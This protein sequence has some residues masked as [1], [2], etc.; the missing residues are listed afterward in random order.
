MTRCSRTALVL[1][2]LAL[3]LAA[4]ASAQARTVRVFAVQ[5]KLDLNWMESRQTYHDKMLALADS[6]LRTP[7]APAV[8]RG[9]AD[10]ASHLLGPSDPGRP[11]ATARDLVVWPEDLGLFAAL[12]GPRAAGARSSGSFV[13]AIVALIGAYGPQNSYYTQRFPEAANRALPVRL[14]E[15]SLTDTYARTAVETFAEMA[16]RYDVYLE[17]GVNMVQDW[18]VVCDDLQA[19]NRA[20]PPRLPG[21]VLCQEQNP[22][23]V[24]QLGDPSELIRD[25]A[26][27]ATTDKV[28]NMALVFDPDGRLISKQVKTYLTPI[29]LPGQ[30]DLV[31]GLVTGGLSAVNTPVGTLGFVTSKDAWMP[32]V[33]AKLDEQHVDVLVQ[34]EFFVNDLVRA[35]GMW[36]P[37]TLKAAGY[38][39]ALRMPSV[40]AMALP[41]LTGNIFDFSADAQSHFALK[42]GRAPVPAGGLVGQPAAP[43][44]VSSPWVVTD[45]ASAGEPFADRRRR[46]G[47]AGKALA[48][49]SGVACADP[50]VAGP[51]E[52]GHVEGVFSHDVQVGSAPRFKRFRGRVKRARL[53]RARPVTS[54]RAPQRNAAIAVAGRRVAAAWEERRGGHDR[55]YFALSRDGGRH[56]PRALRLGGKGDQQWPAV[57]VGARRVTVAW[58]Q[59]A[60]A[61]PPGVMFARSARGGKRFGAARAIDASGAGAQWRPALA[62]G[63]GDTVHAV[64]VDERERSADDDLPQ[65]HV[66][67]ARIVRGAPSGGARKLDEDA[68]VAPA[69]KLDH[70]WAP[71]VAVRGKRVLATWLD[72]QNYDWGVFSRGSADGGASFGEQTRVTDNVEDPNKQQEEL[73]DSPDAAFTGAGTP[74]IAWTDWRGR[75]SAALAPHEEYDTF[76]ASPGGPNRQVDPY[77]ARQVS[78]FAPSLCA[79]GRRDAVVAFQD[80]SRGRSE[81]R[82]V[83]MR[84]GV[85]RGKARL[86]SDA[87]ARG[88][89]AWR[90]RLGCSGARVVAVWEDERDGPPRLY[91]ATGLARRLR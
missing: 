35:D 90:P 34:P 66:L 16:D 39:D 24:R 13:A 52:N 61:D 89:N 4:A 3:A 77:G 73:A 80:S 59:R 54:S 58:S 64:W 67:Y 47:E 21:G 57:A 78:T 79:I 48:P 7:A 68:P 45:P 2:L 37:D 10:L 26:Y 41:E 8:Q 75:D 5:P 29:E 9:A 19:F 6:R 69:A 31:P 32:D 17:V 53:G 72:F 46:L 18:K 74:L 70:A 85:T 28:S 55:V 76:V 44:L 87:G 12:T 42:P 82:A 63:S 15:V 56:W 81:I 22:Q 20:E 71:R 38:N 23:K 11:V 51:C 25:Y 40:K 88:G 84:G 49:G 1:A 62:Q 33:Q 60:G 65:A 36:S 83:T 91:S 14:T 43:G 30:L 50:T 27:E 86:V